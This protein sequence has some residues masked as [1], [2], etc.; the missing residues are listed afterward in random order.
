MG[1]AGPARGGAGAGLESSD[2]VVSPVVEWLG[3]AMTLVA[4]VLLAMIAWRRWYRL[5]RAPRQRTLGL[6]EGLMLGAGT[7]L[8]AWL[9][10]WAVGPLAQVAEG[11]EIADLTL[12]QQTVLLAGA[13]TGGLVVVIL[14]FGV[15]RSDDR[16]AWSLPASVGLGAITFVMVWPIVAGTQV[17]ASWVAQRLSGEP[18]DP[19]SHET[20]RLLIESPGTRWYA[21]MGALVVVMAPLIEEVTYRGIVQRTVAGLHLGRWTPI[22]VTSV[23]FTGVHIAIASKPALPALFVLSLGFGWAAERTGRLAAPIT[24]H[25]LFNAAN[26]ALATMAT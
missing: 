8:M 6:P 16:P 21:L 3:L 1:G 14:F 25:V 13:Y 22:V 7:V 24:M 23:L 20:L 15:V 9:G 10:S 26:L 17:V 19:I 11:T 12:Q 5:D 4:P 18:L 2:S